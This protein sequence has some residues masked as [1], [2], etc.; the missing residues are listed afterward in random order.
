MLLSVTTVSTSLQNHA[1]DENI[2]IFVRLLDQIALFLHALVLAGLFG[3]T[4]EV[5]GPLWSKL[6]TCLAALLAS[7]ADGELA[8]FPR[9]VQGFWG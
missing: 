7:D 1:H 6:G 9:R 5:A 8:A 4:D 2:Q 3:F